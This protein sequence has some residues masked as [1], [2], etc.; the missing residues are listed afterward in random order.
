MFSLWK[1][2]VKVC[3]KSLY[4]STYLSAVSTGLKV[5]VTNCVALYQ[6]F[7]QPLHQLIRS[8]YS[9]FTGVFIALYPQ[10]TEPITT[11]TIYKGGK[12]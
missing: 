2:W 7:T 3:V 11:T 6:Y 8:F 12:I 5:L 10:S 1:I 9:D 4:N